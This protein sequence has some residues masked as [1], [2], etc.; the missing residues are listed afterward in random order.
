SG[1][2]TPLELGDDGVAEV[3][4]ELDLLQTLFAGGGGRVWISNN[5]ALGFLADGSSGAYYLNAEIPSFALF[6]GGHGTPQSLAVYWDDLDSGTGEVYYA[7]VGEPGT[8]VFIVQWQ[9]RPHYPGDVVLDGDEA[10]FQVQI[11]EDATLAYAQFLYQDVDFQ[12]PVLDEGASAT[13]GYQAGGIE[14]NVQW[15][16][17]TPGAV[18]ANTVLTLLDEGCPWDLDGDGVVGLSDLAQL[19]A[20]YG[21]CVGDP[22]FD[23]A[24]DFNDDGC[25]DLSDLAALLSVYG[26]TCP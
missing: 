9:D 3:W 25:V 20:T 4:P 14:N 5:G 22:G 16:F 24:A 6:G 15:S 18:T 12:D 21:L 2:G 13:I 23:G 19:L 26:T 17:N 10:T 11:F 7:T 8:R 1:S